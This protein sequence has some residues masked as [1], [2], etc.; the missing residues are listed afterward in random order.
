MDYLIEEV[1]NIQAHEIKEFLLCTSI[2]N[3]FSEPLCNA[4]LNINTSQ[5]ILESLEREN[6]FIIPLDAERKWYRYHHLFADLLNQQLRSKSN[7]DITEL[8]CK[9]S[10]WYESEDMIL[11]AVDHS[12]KAE[13]YEKAIDLLGSIIE[14]LWKNGQHATIMK[15]SQ[16]LPLEYIKM[17]SEFCLYYSWV[18]IFSGKWQLAKEILEVTEELVL[19][20]IKNNKD[21]EKNKELLGKI[22]VAH[23]NLL[24]NTGIA[25]NIFHYCEQ[26]Q[27]YLSEKDPLWNSWAWFGYGTAHMLVGEVAQSIKALENAVMYAKKTRNLYLTSTTVIRLA[28]TELR[29]GNFKVAFSYCEDLL[30]SIQDGGYTEMVKN[31]WS[32]SGL[33]STMGYIQF[34]WNRLDEALQNSKTAY[35]LCRK[36]DDVILHLFTALIYG[37]VL[38]LKGY[39]IKSDEIISE[40][41]TMT[42]VKNVPP[43]LV[44]MFL[45]WKIDEYIRQE[46]Y[47]SA[48]RI[49]E[50]LDLSTD[51]DIDF[52]NELVNIS[53]ARYLISQ[54][55]LDE[56]KKILSQVHPL[57]ESGGRIER[58]I[59]IKTLYAI[60]YNYTDEHENALVYLSESIKLAKEEN[61]L[62]FFIIEGKEILELL[63]EL[64][65]QQS[66]AQEKTT[67]KFLKEIILTIEKRE[68]RSNDPSIEILSKREIEVLKLIADKHTNQQIADSLFISLNTVKTHVKNIHLKLDV[69]DRTAAV[70]KVREMGII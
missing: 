21:S 47:D 4:V 12:L 25:D 50:S 48:Y 27:K 62:M 53:F 15:Y 54:Y 36:G 68:S 10:L 64:Y 60:L 26:A 31:E 57:A 67:T 5:E 8:H 69:Y 46:K 7:I 35:E 23:I 29:H 1:L 6:M 49:I 70:A 38:L 61:L 34:R 16:I 20:R 55:R 65:K 13:D 41:E 17:N 56:A 59:E 9:A 40:L 22:S 42:K 51:M 33:F 44:D 28:F 18:L 66:T 58:L 39:R 14:Q 19:E 2:L 32:Y 63:R 24:T 37:W 52:F 45:T 11:P 30:K 43:Y 3:Q